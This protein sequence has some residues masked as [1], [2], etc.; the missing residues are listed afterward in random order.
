MIKDKINKIDQYDKSKPSKE[1]PSH[2]K[3]NHHLSPHNEKQLQ[4]LVSS[5]MKGKNPQPSSLSTH[6]DVPGKK[7]LDMISVST[8]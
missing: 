2:T 8:G 3:I 5:K 7:S 4:T 1:E 6:I